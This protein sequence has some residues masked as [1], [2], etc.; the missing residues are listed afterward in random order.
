MKYGREVR[1]EEKFGCRLMDWHRDSRLVKPDYIFFAIRGLTVDGHA[2]IQKAIERGASVVFCEAWPEEIRETVTYVKVSNS[3]K[4]MALIAKM[5]FDNPSNRLRLV[6]VT[7]TNGKTTVVT[8]LHQLF[9]DLGYKVGLLSTIRTRINKADYESQYTTPDV[10]KINE[11]LSEMADAGCD[12]V[13]MEVSSHAVKQKRIQGL[14]FA[15]AIFTNLTHDHLDYHKTFDDYIRHKKM[16]FDHLPSSAFAL[17]NVDD[18]RGEVM[19][20][21]TKARKYKYSFK[22]LVDFHGKII[23]SDLSGLKL[24]FNEETFHSQLIGRFNGLQFSWRFMLQVFC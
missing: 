11:L 10:L 9:I 16:F 24:R 15:G 5:F 3:R 17:V 20:Q 14:E 23:E 1:L 7:G 6:G 12:Y 18:R 4:S 22:Q 21:N 8:L 13:F 19:I 2:Y